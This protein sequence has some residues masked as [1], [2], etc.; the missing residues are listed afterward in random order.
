MPCDTLTAQLTQF[1]VVERTRIEVREKS[2]FVENRSRGRGEII[3]GRAISAGRQP[4]RGHVVAQLG[5]LAQ[6]E[7]C[8]RAASGRAGAR[9]LQDLI[10]V[11]I[12]RG[13]SRRGLG[14][15]AVA[16]AV[17]TE[18]REGDEDLG[19]VRDDRSKERAGPLRRVRSKVGRPSGDQLVGG[20]RRRGDGH[21]V[22]VWC[23]PRT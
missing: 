11:E 10:E 15:R 7:E 19:G 21:A 9:D 12:R 2:R 18:H 20:V 16:T 14:E 1:V 4:L 6:R 17:P 8:L 23:R 5:P 22:I 13:E 3:D